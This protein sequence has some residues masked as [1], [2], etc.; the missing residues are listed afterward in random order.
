MNFDLYSHTVLLTRAG[1]R[2]YGIHTPTSDLDVKGVAIPPVE[3]VLGLDV[4]EQADKPV[5]FEDERFRALLTEDERTIVAATKLEGSIYD[6]RKFLKLALEGNPNILDAL[7]CRDED[8][9]TWHFEGHSGTKSAT[10]LAKEGFLLREHRDLFISAKCKH[11]FSGY[12]MA[13][14][15]RINLHRRWLLN[16]PTHRPTRAEHGLPKSTLI[17]AD[18][19]AA[20][21]SM[22]KKKLDE[23]E[24]DFSTIT[25][26]ADRFSLT[27]QIKGT[28][29]EVIA[30]LYTD[31][32]EQDAKWRAAVKAVGLDDNLLA[33]MEKERKYKGAKSEWDSYNNWEKTRNPERAALEAKYGY[34]VKHGCHLVR[35]MRMSKEIMLTG[36][37]NVCREGIDADELRAIRSGAWSYDRVIEFAEAEQKIIDEVYRSKA[38]VVPHVP[39]REGVNKLCI[40]LLS[41]VSNR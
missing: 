25:D 40:K 5:H 21:E 37:V 29:S 6:L 28:V 31:V 26:E 4:F 12:A 32:S 27:E 17:P 41:S 1:S 8:V 33:I 14:L 18:Q 20:A 10:P 19:L 35:L 22:V 36:K 24:F 7:F 39:D 23:W 9:L 38:Y 3:F 13:Q 11:T 15:K 34:D 2:A 30:G 16:P